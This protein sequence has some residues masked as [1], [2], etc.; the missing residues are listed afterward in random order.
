MK[1]QRRF[2]NSLDAQE[3]CLK[4]GECAEPHRHGKDQGAENVLKDVEEYTLSGSLQS[5]GL[6]M[7]ARGA[8][9]I[10]LAHWEQLFPTSSLY[11]G[12]G[13]PLSLTFYCLWHHHVKQLALYLGKV[14]EG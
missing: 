13:V 11:N 5:P 1:A 6:N 4:E 10:S 9:K 3:R 14:V 7:Q 2:L 8:K 12:S